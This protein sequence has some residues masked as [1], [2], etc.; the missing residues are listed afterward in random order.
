MIILGQCV[1]NNKTQKF[2]IW[3][4]INSFVFIFNCGFNLVV[5]FSC[6]KELIGGKRKV[7]SSGFGA[8]CECEDVA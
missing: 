8:E 4:V 1:V 6:D 2:G 5:V 7:S 3:G